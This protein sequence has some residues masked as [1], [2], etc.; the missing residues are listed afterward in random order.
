MRAIVLVL[1]LALGA[2]ALFR[3]TPAPTDQVCPVPVRYSMEFQAKLA[4]ELEALPAGSALGQAMI[5]Y[6]QERAQLR[7]CHSPLQ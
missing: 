2:C 4:D 5:D 1:L 7:A 6:G 3:P